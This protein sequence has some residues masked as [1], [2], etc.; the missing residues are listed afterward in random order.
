MFLYAEGASHQNAVIIDNLNRTIE[1]YDPNGADNQAEE[2]GWQR[3]W[4]D[5]RNSYLRDR[6]YSLYPTIDICVQGS[7]TGGTC[8]AWSLLV[9]LLRISCPS[10]P[11]ETILVR[12]RDSGVDG[13][14]RIIANWLRAMWQ[15]THFHINRSE[16][17]PASSSDYHL[18]NLYSFELYFANAPVPLYDK[19]A[20]EEDE[21]YEFNELVARIEQENLRRKQVQTEL[22]TADSPHQLINSSPNP[23]VTLFIDEKTVLIG[24]HTDIA[25]DEGQWF[26]AL[27]IGDRDVAVLNFDES[28]EFVFSH[29][30]YRSDFLRSLNLLLAGEKQQVFNSTFHE[31]HLLSLWQAA[32][33]QPLQEPVSDQD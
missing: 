22:T 23:V 21:D 30:T 24:K 27:T 8:V 25:G 32:R 4:A 11:L 13:R 31:V 18:S 6:G 16:P 28:G 3:W 26:L 29:V 2:E 19:Y 14:R 20:Q 10:V 1:R 17:R 33:R 7:Q 5:P 15:L 12:I 9:L